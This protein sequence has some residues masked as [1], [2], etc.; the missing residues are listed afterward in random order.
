MIAMLKPLGLTLTLLST[1][2]APWQTAAT[3]TTGT[4]AL[5]WQPCPGDTST[6]AAT[7][8]KPATK[9]ATTTKPTGSGPADTI[10]T[11][12]TTTGL[13]CADLQ[14]PA[15][16][17]KPEGRKI[18]LK[19]GRLKATGGTAKGSVLVSYGGPGAPGI[20]MTRSLQSWW[21]DL[22]KSMDIVT[23]DTRGY[24]ADQFQGLSTG[25]PCTWTRI[26]LAD[27]PQD[28]ADL[29]RLSD[30]NRGY[31]EACRLK[32][33]ELFAN[34][35]SADH[36]RDMEAIRKALGD[37]QLNY[38][39]ASY[40]GFYGQAYARLFPSRVRT[41][42]LDGTWN[43]S[44]A[45]WQREL[46]AMAA[47]NEQSMRRFFTW[48]TRNDCA[49]VPA[50]WRKLIAR[51]ASKPIPANTPNV[52]YK[53]GDLQSFA[54]GLA[55]QGTAAWPKLATA[56]RKASRGDASD[57][58]PASGARYPDQATPVT[59]CTDWPR[60]ADL[61]QLTATIKRLRKLAPNAGAANTF[62]TST[63]NCIGW[64][65]P[66]TN[67]PAPLPTG[68]PPLLGAGAWGESDATE[69]ILAQVPGSVTIHHDGPGHTLYGT[70]PCARDHINAYLTSRTLPPSKTQC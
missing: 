17:Q 69:R 47:T 23:W 11:K 39:G 63:L 54:L 20:A 5:T 13:E 62:A 31:A 21:T 53:T 9:P 1:P 66:V 24:G 8:T 36:A 29:G 12:T 58:V 26:P 64:P 68:L 51:A 46:E 25:L 35:S 57:F 19:L 40:A 44:A 6:A 43:H 56:I 42:V 4:T 60:F 48:C 30:T 61:S 7:T 45:D 67:P 27:V 55:R 15:D 28:D 70:N 49:D 50:L 59:E 37:D 18:T 14:V 52:A 33:R 32:D 41:M 38:Y 16:W 10:A 3:T 65:V 34:M 22:R 2:L